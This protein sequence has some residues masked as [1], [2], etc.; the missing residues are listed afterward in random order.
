METTAHLPWDIIL[1]I[2]CRLP[3]KD[4]L[5]FRCVSK[6]WCSLIGGSDFINLHLKHSPESTFQIG[7]AFGGNTDICWASLND[8]NSFVRLTCPIDIGTGLSVQGSINGLLAIMNHSFDMAIWNPFIRRYISLPMSHHF[9]PF[10]EFEILLTG[11][12]HDPVT[13]DY[14]LVMLIEFNELFT[15]S[16][17]REVKLYS[18]NAKKWKKIDDSPKHI[19]YGPP[20]HGDLFGA[21]FGNALHWLAESKHDNSDLIL[22]FDLVTET[23]RHFPLPENKCHCVKLVNLGDSLCAVILIN[24]PPRVEVWGVK[25]YG[26]NESW[27]LLFSVPPTKPTP[28]CNYT[29]PIAYLKNSDEVLLH[30]SEKLFVYDIKRKEFNKRA[31]GPGLPE[32]R[33]ALVCVKSLVG[34]GFGESTCNG[35]ERGGNVKGGKK[36]TAKQRDDFLSKG[37]KLRL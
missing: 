28:P 11:F 13:D 9:L 17:H 7:F 34:L 14:K 21:L 36:H 6:S 25:E 33:D 1:V 30:D 24:T 5:R 26:V 27:V 35:K 3:V 16:S 23:F 8:L 10:H 32:I 12:G 18:L 19:T 4:L 2:L 22:V 31:V 20:N 29:L 37:F 15:R